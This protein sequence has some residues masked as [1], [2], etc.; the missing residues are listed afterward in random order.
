M[1]PELKFPI[2]IKFLNLGYMGTFKSS[3]KALRLYAKICKRM[4]MYFY[5]E[6]M[7]SG[8]KI[9]IKVRFSKSKNHLLKK[10]WSTR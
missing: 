9:L 4:Y 7:Y 2:I 1:E 5:W 6:M 3:A 10:V 8:S